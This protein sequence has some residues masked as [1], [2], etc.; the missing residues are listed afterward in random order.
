M[1]IF[2]FFDFFCVSKIVIFFFKKNKIFYARKNALNNFFFENF[3][4]SKIFG[5]KKVLKRKILS[6]IYGGKLT[7]INLF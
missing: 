4:S 3:L 2:V 6:N 7:E 5:N 1:G